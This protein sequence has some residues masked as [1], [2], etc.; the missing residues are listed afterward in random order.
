MCVCVC[1][2][3]LCTL[4]TFV[5][6]HVIN[7]SIYYYADTCALLLRGV[8]GLV[9]QSPAGYLTF[10]AKTDC[11]ILSHASNSVSPLQNCCLTWN[12]SAWTHTYRHKHLACCMVHVSGYKYAMTILCYS[13]PFY[14]FAKFLLPDPDKYK[15]SFTHRFISYL[16]QN[17]KLLRNYTQNVDQLERAAGITRL[18]ESHGTLRTFKCIRCKCDAQ[19]P[20]TRIPNP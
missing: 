7:W 4:P 8:Q 9:Y 13:Q 15:P 16:E 11:I 1:V 20:S 3:P 19:L 12:T 18:C 5:Y 17:N 14:K 6:A 2:L 10:E